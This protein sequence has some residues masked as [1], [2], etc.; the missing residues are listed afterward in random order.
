LLTLQNSSPFLIS[1]NV[2]NGRFYFSS[3][4]LSIDETNFTQHALF[5]ATLI[6]MAEFSQPTARLSY[7]LGREEAI[8]LR[9]V[10]METEETF[11]IQSVNGAMEIIP[12]HRNAGNQIEVFVHSD[13]T[14]AGNFLLTRAGNAIRPLAFNFD[15][16]ESH[17]ETISIEEFEQKISD[18]NLTNWSVLETDLESI[19][20]E[21]NAIDGSHKYWLSLIIWALIFL[22]IEILLIK[23][24]R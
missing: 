2:G 12:E 20:A 24:W 19:G 1:S 3:V 7:T 8:E 11:R 10:S 21:A 4:S 14:Q 15:R 17:N 6:R 13:L 9:N 5:P 16:A 18:Q 23:F 22:A